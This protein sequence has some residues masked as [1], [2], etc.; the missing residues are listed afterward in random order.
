MLV[1]FFDKLV[2]FYLKYD[3][4]MYENVKWIEEYLGKIIVWGY[5]GYVLKINMFFFIYFKVVG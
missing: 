1:I 3:I 5:N 4:V 2:D